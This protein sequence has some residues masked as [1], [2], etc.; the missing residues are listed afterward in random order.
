MTKCQG[1]SGGAATDY[2]GIA[3]SVGPRAELSRR[4]GDSGWPHVGSATHADGGGN[5]PA[6]DLFVLALVVMCIAVVALAAVQSRQKAKIGPKESTPIDREDPA[7]AS[8][9]AAGMTVPGPW[10]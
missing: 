8:P 7:S 4:R 10:S 3:H 6:S 9:D 1:V 2:A 5:V